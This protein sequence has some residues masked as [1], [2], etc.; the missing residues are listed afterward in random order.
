[1]VPQCEKKPCKLYDEMY[2]MTYSTQMSL[3][4]GK[5]G[6]PALLCRLCCFLAS[7]YLSTFSMYVSI[8]L[9]IHF[10]GT[11]NRERDHGAVRAESSLPLAEKEIPARHWSDF[12]STLVYKSYTKR[13]L[14]KAYCFILYK[15]FKSILMFF[16]QN[17]IQRTFQLLQDFTL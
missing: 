17:L 11:R 9:S 4:Q 14:V 5:P 3:F 7:N 13:A 12:F 1:M 10:N 2:T 16:Y 6:C 8:N 15:F